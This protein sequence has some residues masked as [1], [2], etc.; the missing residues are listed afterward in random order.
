MVKFAY[1]A[2][3]SLHIKNSYDHQ[4]TENIYIRYSYYKIGT[5][6]VDIPISIDLLDQ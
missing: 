3:Q 6:Q 4:I 5:L 1:S 2:I